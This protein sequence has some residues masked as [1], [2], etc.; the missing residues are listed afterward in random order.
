MVIGKTTFSSLMEQS[1]SLNFNPFPTP[2]KAKVPNWDPTWAL[3]LEGHGKESDRLVGDADSVDL[4]HEHG[5]RKIQTRPSRNIRRALA[6][7]LGWLKMGLLENQIAELQQDYALAT[8]QPLPSGA[9]LV[10][11]PSIELPTGW[12]KP[13]TTVRFVVPAGFPHAQPDCFWADADLRLQGQGMPQNSGPNQ[14]P[15]YGGTF[16]WFSWHLAHPWNP[17]QDTLRTWV[18]VI[19][20]RLREAH[21]NSGVAVNAPGYRRAILWQFKRGLRNPTSSPKL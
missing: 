9:A 3:L 8:L 2:I 4:S 21:E 12:S 7:V 5:P 6:I 20:R 10:T 19:M 13:T 17:N 16:L 11:V 15:E 18:A 1:T 14:I